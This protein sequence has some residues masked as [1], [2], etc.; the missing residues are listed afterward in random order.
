[1]K[2]AALLNIK[3]DINIMTVKVADAVNLL[4]LEITPMEIEIFTGYNT[5]LI[6]ICREVNIQIG[7]I[8]NNVNIF[9]VQESAYP[10]LLKM[11][12]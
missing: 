10:L 4:I 3:A 9:V 1:V 12:Y 8:C 2:V 11:P 6:G 7:A 5:Q